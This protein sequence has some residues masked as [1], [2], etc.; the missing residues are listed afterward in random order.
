MALI[1]CPEC[2]KEVSDKAGK[3]PQ[4]GCPIE[5]RKDEGVNNNINIE[6]SS[7]VVSNNEKIIMKTKERRPLSKNAIIG[8]ILVIVA[9]IIGITVYLVITADSRNYKAGQNLYAEEK[10]DE[11][12]EKF[13][14]L[15]GYKDSKDMIEKCEYE[16]SV[17][18]QFL[19]AL[20]KGLMARWDYSDGGYI[21][22]F[23]KEEEEM[24]SDEFTE[25]RKNC[26]NKELDSIGRFQSEIFDNKELGSAAKEYIDLLNEAIDTIGYYDIDYTKYITSW[27][28]IYTKRSVYIRDF[29]EKYGMTVDEKHQKELDD[30]IVNASVVDKQEKVKKDIE[31]MISGF[32]FERNIDEWGHPTY[33]LM[34]ENTTEYTFDYFYVNIN[35]LDDEG[36]IIATGQAS[37]IEAWQPGQKAT[38]D[39]WLDTRGEVVDYSSIEFTAHYNTEDYF[40]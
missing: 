29:A 9:V 26:V 17:D 39:A 1:K 38:V 31:N 3:C 40:E 35:A 22:D 24:N 7:D 14:A 34:M 13:S 11:A 8:I 16:L 15:E 4:C 10:Y 37:Q 19:K 20:S 6:E 30:F 2:G 18:G 12:L 28:E 25:F 23:E 27:D 32:N 33:K 21:N 5:E 36:N